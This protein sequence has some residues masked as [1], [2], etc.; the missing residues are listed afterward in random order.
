[1]LLCCS[2]HLHIAVKLK[3]KGGGVLKSSGSLVYYS[4][5]VQQNVAVEQRIFLGIRT[6]RGSSTEN[7]MS[8]PT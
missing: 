8:L 2:V 1:M 7:S 4:H 5:L 6:A 3:G